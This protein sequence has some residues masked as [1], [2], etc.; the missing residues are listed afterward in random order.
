MYGQSLTVSTIN[1]GAIS[2]LA[3]WLRRRCCVF[4]TLLC[5][6][7]IPACSSNVPSIQSGS[8]STLSLPSAVEQPPAQQSAP[9]QPAPEQPAPQQAAPQ[10]PAPQQPAPQQ[11]PRARPPQW[12]LILGGPTRHYDRGMPTYSF[13][14]VRI[15]ESTKYRLQVNSPYPVRVTTVN[16]NDDTSS[17]YLAGDDCINKMLSSDSVSCVIMVEFQPRALGQKMATVSIGVEC[18][19]TGTVQCPNTRWSESLE[20]DGEGATGAQPT[21]TQPTHPHPTR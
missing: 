8:N 11:P 12:S 18:A 14:K 16:L 6:S 20:L 2:R 17:F 3:P 10:Q 15:G 7:F 13:A 5:L 19:S 4:V 21:V 9:E 1:C